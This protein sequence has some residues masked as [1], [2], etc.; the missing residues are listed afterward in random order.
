MLFALTGLFSAGLLGCEQVINPSPFPKSASPTA[1]PLRTLVATVPPSTPQDVMILSVEENGY[2][3][4]FVFSPATSTF[5][6]ITSGQWN[7]I[8]PALSPDGKSVAFA[9]DRGG[10][11][12]I[13]VLD[14]LNGQVSQLTN[15]P[16][17]DSSPTWSPDL[18]WIAF[19]T[20]QNGS[21]DI[22]ILSLIEPDKAAILLTDD[23]AS[24]H[25]PAWAPNG[26]EIAFVSDSG[27]NADIWIADLNK[28][29][30]RFAD[31]SNSPQAADSHPIWSPDG[32]HLAWGSSSQ[33]TDYD[34][35][36]VWDAGEPERP[37]SWVGSGDWPAWNSA[38]NE[39]AT[40]VNAANEQL[41]TAFTLHGQ[42]VLLPTPLPGHLRGLAWPKLQMAEPLPESMRAAASETPQ[43]LS[44]A[45]ITP[46]AGV[47]AKRWYVVPLP[48]VDA[49]YPEMHVLADQSFAALRKRV[50]A[51]AGWD[52]LASLENAYVPLTTAL[53]PGLLR[54]AFA[55]QGNA[56]LLGEGLRATAHE[57]LTL[58]P[59][60]FRRTEAQRLGLDPLARLAVVREA[61]RG[62]ASEPDHRRHVHP[63][64]GHARPVV[65]GRDGIEQIHQ[66]RGDHPGRAT[67]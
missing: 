52:A 60:E 61:D 58:N 14:L 54:S 57:V 66:P 10:H 30:N 56:I 33:G 9:S 34:G 50:I 17:Y 63:A 27:G 11:W 35:I 49:P 25:S 2:A 43:P 45:P 39:I 44:Q 36:Y 22:A 62:H 1:E 20:Y 55:G 38:G 7:D 23:S 65:V 5:T 26:R 47:P 59:P 4:L 37:A 6:R 29:D 41:L 40:M 28:T 64:H 18:A 8:T 31:L 53:D 24:E 21:L 32:S 51:E 19:E 15:T 3:H 16:E 13:Y 67:G 12:D 46:E 42:P 48:D